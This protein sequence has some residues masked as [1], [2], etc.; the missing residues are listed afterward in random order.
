MQAD[1]MSLAFQAQLLTA[2][3]RVVVHDCG[4]CERTLATCLLCSCPM[5]MDICYR[6]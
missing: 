4:T 5:D 3:V 1:D 2:D 6:G